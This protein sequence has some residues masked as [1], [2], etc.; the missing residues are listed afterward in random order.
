MTISRELFLSI[1]ALDAYNRGSG[2]EVGNLVTRAAP[3]IGNAQVLQDLAVE[4]AGFYA[5]AYDVSDVAEFTAVGITK[6]IS[7]RGTDNL[8]PL[9]PGNDVINGWAA[10]L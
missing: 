4:A 6:V 1:L 3:G 10:A 9:K 8:D 2:S 5:V 7:Y